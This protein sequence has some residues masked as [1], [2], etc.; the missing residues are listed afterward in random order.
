MWVSVCRPFYAYGHQHQS[1]TR[2]R[3]VAQV[4]AKVTYDLP[5]VPLD[6][7]MFSYLKI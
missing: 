7:Y 3:H 6:L 2:K 5:E 1:R 4:V